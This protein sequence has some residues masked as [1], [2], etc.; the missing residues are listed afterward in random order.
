MQQLQAMEAE[1]KARQAAMLMLPSSSDEDSSE[2]E[3]KEE[4]TDRFG[5][6]I[7]PQQALAMKRKAQESSVSGGDVRGQLSLEEV[8]R[9]V[10]EEGVRSLNHREKKLHQE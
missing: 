3:K 4:L 1:R 6:T 10:E 8:L 7:T 2:H 5:N 9:K